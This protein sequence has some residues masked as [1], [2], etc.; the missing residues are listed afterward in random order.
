LP[1]PDFE[2]QYQQIAKEIKEQIARGDLAPGSRLSSERVLGSQFQ[3]QR[4]TIRQALTLLEQE[5]RISTEQRRG[6][7]VLPLPEADIGGT[8]VVNMH[9]GS[10]SNLTALLEGF[11]HTAEER[12]FKV[13]R[14]N[15]N[16]VGTSIMNVIP[17]LEELPS[18][19]AGVV[20]WPHYPTDP[21]RLRR[22][23]DRV[24]LVLV[25]RHVIGVSADCVRFDDIHGGK[26][27]TEHLLSL[28]HR[29]IAFLTDEV[30][31]ET[32]QLRWHG[33][34]WAQEEAG[35][36]FDTKLSLLYQHMDT[37]IFSHTFRMLMADKSSRP[38]A[39]VCANDLVAFSLLRFLHAE[40]I[41]TPED[42]AVTGYGNA[43]PDYAEAMTLTTI[44]QPFSEVGKEAARL[45]VSRVHQTAQERLKKPEDKILPVKLVVRGS[46]VAK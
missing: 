46:T 6:S 4:N 37:Q 45:L 30:F 16:P 39:V 13:V 17:D 43:M 25:D 26:L 32:V 35:C 10:G 22:L 41:K 21:D 8:F 44:D 14:R 29:R 20:V 31:A 23:N 33:Y 5:G 1:R 15:T 12:G 7:F 40:G 24:P 11:S 27:I 38:T 2:Y 36:Q 9:R 28:G 34:V 3:V 42:V 19:T 18:E